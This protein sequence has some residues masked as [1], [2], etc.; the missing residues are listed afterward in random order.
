MSHKTDLTIHKVQFGK[1]SARAQRISELLA[2]KIDPG[3]R[4][5]FALF[6]SFCYPPEEQ[7][8]RSSLFRR[9]MGISTMTPDSAPAAHT[10]RDQVYK[11]LYLYDSIKGVVARVTPQSMPRIV[12][13]TGAN[14]C[15]TGLATELYDA[16]I[17]TSRERFDDLSTAT[18]D[19]E[20][21]ARLDADQMISMELLTAEQFDAALAESDLHRLAYY[22]SLPSAAS[23]R[24]SLRSPRPR[25]Y[26]GGDIA[27]WLA[28]FLRRQNIGLQTPPTDEIT[29]TL[30]VVEGNS[31][32]L[33][34]VDVSAL[35]KL[36]LTLAGQSESP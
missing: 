34:P 13:I 36:A 25:E 11:A 33:A 15:T 31:D 32:R 26:R 3:S 1:S 10:G 9:L 21:P 35:A 8:R 6:S 22:F 4:D 7:D 17:Y 2:D 19:P 5:A 18:H 23:I 16:T 30:K 27:Q 14:N 29:E 24:N 20:N 12:P 28:V